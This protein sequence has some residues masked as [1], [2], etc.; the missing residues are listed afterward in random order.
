[1]SNILLFCLKKH[2]KKTIIL[3]NFGCDC[4]KDKEIITSLKSYYGIFDQDFFN[5]L[6]VL[7]KK[8][9]LVLENNLHL[10]TDINHYESRL[11][12]DI[13]LSPN[14]VLDLTLS[15]F[16]SVNDRYNNIVVNLL[17]DYEI[18][19]GDILDSSV[20][21]MF[22]SGNYHDMA[23]LVHELVHKIVVGDCQASDIPIFNNSY[24]E[25][26]YLSEV[27]SEI[28]PYVMEMLACDYCEYVCGKNIF[29]DNTL[30][31]LIMVSNSISDIRYIKNINN[32]FNNIHF[33]KIKN[34]DKITNAHDFFAQQM[35]GINHC[36]GM[37]IACCIYWKIIDNLENMK[38]FLGL[39]KVLGT[40]DYTEHSMVFLEKIGF[41]FVVDGKFFLD[42]ER[43]EYIVA[44]FKRTIEKCISNASLNYS[45]IF[46]NELISDSLFCD[47]NRLYNGDNK[48]YIK[49]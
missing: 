6:I 36:L 17:N 44:L 48:L 20:Y 21:S 7:I 28:N 47:V 32:T 43:I 19:K 30:Y 9:N 3:L 16:E 23:I 33:S 24:F 46:S 38:I 45:C 39:E 49:K 25:F 29:S 26:N 37:M 2:E 35:R 13:G 18:R 40:V 5:K 27:L 31:N 1:M 4:L 11:R 12:A 22:F 14:K 41:P 42:Q 15:F 8:C 10:K 34:Y